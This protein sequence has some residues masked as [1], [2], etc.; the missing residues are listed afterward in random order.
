MTTSEAVRLLSGCNRWLVECLQKCD[1][2]AAEKVIEDRNKLLRDLNASL[3]QPD[4]SR[5]E[6]KRLAERRQIRWLL[7][8]TQAEN[9]RC[10]QELQKRLEDQRNHLKKVK[11]GRTT[12]MLYKSPP[13]DN[14]RFFDQRG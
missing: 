8:D 1:W 3:N 6:E 2:Q 12:L 14:P 4:Q 10:I 5:S 11:R 13:R 7:E 9:D